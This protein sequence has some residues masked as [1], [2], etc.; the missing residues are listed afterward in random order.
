MMKR[1][2]FRDILA[3]FATCMLLGLAGCGEETEEAAIILKTEPANGGSM[4]ANGN[5]V[6]TFDKVVT[7]V[8]VNGILADVD[9]TIATWEGQLLQA[10]EQTLEI[11]WTD[12][13]GNIDTEEITL[14]IMEPD[15]TAC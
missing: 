11:E 9:G 14:T 4:F 10:G 7:E 5:L 12:E 13:N 8:T 3:I 2:L 1:T 15:L 6:I